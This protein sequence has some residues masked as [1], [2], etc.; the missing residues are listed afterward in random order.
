MSR[1]FFRGL[2][3]IAPLALTVAILAWLFLILE[4]VSSVVIQQII[5]EQYY[6]PGLGIIICLIFIFFIG[7]VINNFLIQKIYQYNDRLFRKIPLIKTVY[8]AISDLMGFF[9][10]EKNDQLSQVVILKVGGVKLLGFV[11][12]ETFDDLPEGLGSKEDIVVY[13]PFSYQIGGYTCVVPKKDIERINMTVEEGMRFC[14]TA[15]ILK[16]HKKT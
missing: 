5:G 6:F 13:V 1:I 12:R 7:T 11:T 15:G 14:V 3:A 16:K 2:I 8:N 9:Q 4:S 10:S